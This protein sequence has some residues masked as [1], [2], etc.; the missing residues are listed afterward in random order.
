[1]N[2]QILGARSQPP[3][4]LQHL[5]GGTSPLLCP[6]FVLTCGFAVAS[7]LYVQLQ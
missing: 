4:Q 5:E 6:R 7:S 1:L 2:H 3:G